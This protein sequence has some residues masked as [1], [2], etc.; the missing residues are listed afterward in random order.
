MFFKGPLAFVGSWTPSTRAAQDGPR[1][2]VLEAQ[3][4]VSERPAYSKYIMA[5]SMRYLSGVHWICVFLG[6]LP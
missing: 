1:N 2:P 6:P 4:G 3:P 5:P